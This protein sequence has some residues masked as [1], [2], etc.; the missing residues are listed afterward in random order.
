MKKGLRPGQGLGIRELE[1][2]WIPACAG[3]TSK[4]VGMGANL[5]P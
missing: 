2:I 1:E 5:L 4:A 3:M